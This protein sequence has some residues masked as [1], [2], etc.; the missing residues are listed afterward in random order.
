LDFVD[1]PE[2]YGTEYDRELQDS[3]Y[4]VVEEFTYLDFP[5]NILE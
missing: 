1:V 3:S 2:E 4:I 5:N